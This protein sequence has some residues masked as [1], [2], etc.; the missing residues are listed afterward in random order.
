MTHQV[1]A[2]VTGASSGIG[3][4]I[5]RLLATQ[6]LNLVLVSRRLQA[7]NVLAAELES[8]Y[9]I[10]AHSVSADLSSKKGVDEVL[11][12][13]QAN[14]L[15]IDILVN[16]AGSGLLGEHTEFGDHDIGMMLYLNVISV[17]LLCRAYGAEMKKRKNGRILNI[18]STAA[19]Q[20]TP[21]MSAYGASKSFVLHFSEG[22]AK[23][24]E[25]VGVSVCCVSP[26]PTDTSF[27]DGFDP[28]GVGAGMFRMSN[29]VD[30]KRVAA[31]AID[32][33]FKGHLSKIVGTKHHFAAL[34]TR[35][36]SRA[37]VARISKKMMLAE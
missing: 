8:T 24:L 2:L 10:K 5:S 13:T 11:A 23:E 4:E 17:S 25:D 6:G 7:L 12:H 33:M 18:A 14:Q 31:I 30:A 34:S 29:R 27:F 19:F 36:V 28:Q 32:T 9:S 35:L 16:N 37:A 21:F 20:P 15:T 26:G 3:A 1:Y 22:L